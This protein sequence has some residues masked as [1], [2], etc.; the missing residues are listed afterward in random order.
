MTLLRLVSQC[1]GLRDVMAG[2]AESSLVVNEKRSRSNRCF[3]ASRTASYLPLLAAVLALLLVGIVPA[4]AQLATLYN[5][6]NGPDG[7]TPGGIVVGPNGE[8]YGSSFFGTSGYGT[9]FDLTTTW[10][11]SLSVLFNFNGVDGWFPSGEMVFDAQGNL[12]STTSSGGTFG[13]GTVFRLSPA[14][15]ETVL[16]NFPFPGAATV[17]QK[18]KLLDGATPGPL[19]VDSQ[20]N[21]YGVTQNG[22]VASP[23][24]RRFVNYGNSTCGT[25]F[26]VTAAG[27]EKVLYR[28]GGGKDGMQPLAAM[29]LDGQ[30]NLYGTTGAGGTNGLG[31]V[32]KLSPAGTETVLYSFA[33]GQDAVNPSSRLVLDGQ[34]NLYGTTC[35]GGTFGWGT[36]YEVTA[37]GS[38][39]VLYSFTGGADGG[40]PCAG[41]VR[42][43]RGNFYGSAGVGGANGSGTLYELSSSGAF[44]VLYNFSGGA[45]GGGPGELFFEFSPLFGTNGGLFGTTAIGGD[46]RVC[47]HK[48]EQGCGTVFAFS[49]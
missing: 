24:C 14:G 30:G 25:V 8:L 16:Y 1:S 3:G 27:A 48:G 44:S 29:V 18:H 37:S 9:V 21:L 43:S 41:L 2:P 15:V 11:Y 26:E 40:E 42:D 35:A 20:G 12:Y 6:E 19:V 32:F 46:T 17:S 23:G 10:P 47:V 5:F 33:G 45:D 13:Y 28:F 4:H 34:A 39:S 22:G 38:E 36:I 7:Q 31:T 49:L